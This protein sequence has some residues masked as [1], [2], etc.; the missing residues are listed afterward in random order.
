MHRNRSSHAAEAQTE[1][2][3]V[4]CKRGSSKVDPTIAAV[5][6]GVNFNVVLRSGMSKKLEDSVAKKIV[7]LHNDFRW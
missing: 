2:T 6:V 3:K 5:L 1:F 4:T 7:G